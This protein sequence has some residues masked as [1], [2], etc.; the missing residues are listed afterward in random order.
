MAGKR[1]IDTE[2]YG[3]VAMGNPESSFT[4]RTLVVSYDFSKK[5]VPKS[6]VVPMIAIPKGFYITSLAVIQTKETNADID[7]VT[8][9]L[10]SDS[11]KSVGEAVKLGADKLVRNASVANP[12]FCENADCLCM[13]VPTTITGADAITDGCVEICVRGFEA[14]CEGV[15]GLYEDLESDQY[16]KN[17]Q[18]KE[19]SDANVSGGQFGVSGMGAIADIT[20]PA[21][22]G[23]EG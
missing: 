18:T 21:A 15:A 11:D 22:T 14:F 5:A 23:D 4:E 10:A 13:I 20:K 8:F 19:Q 6:A 16:R 9:G 3:S 12:Q 7:N 2:F 1:T 17:L